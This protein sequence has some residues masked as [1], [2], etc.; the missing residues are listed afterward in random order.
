M[1]NL[2]NFSVAWCHAVCAIRGKR[3]AMLDNCAFCVVPCRH[4][5]RHASTYRTGADG[6]G[7]TWQP[8]AKGR[9]DTLPRRGYSRRLHPKAAR[10]QHPASAGYQAIKI[11]RRHYHEQSY[12]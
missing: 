8:R 1:R 7:P 10:Y 9:R 12:S 6:S 5:K 3:G 11:Y 2:H 4:S